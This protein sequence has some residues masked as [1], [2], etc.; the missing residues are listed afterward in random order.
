MDAEDLLWV[1]SNALTQMEGQISALR[2]TADEFR[3]YGTV[4]KLPEELERFLPAEVR[5]TSVPPSTSVP[6]RR[7]HRGKSRP[8]RKEKYSADE[9]CHSGFAKIELHCPGPRAKDVRVLIPGLE[10]AWIS[11]ECAVTLEALAEH[12]G[13][14]DGKLVAFKT[15]AELA[16]RIA[17][18]S[19]SKL[20]LHSIVSRISR[21]RKALRQSGL[22][23]T[24]RGKGVPTAYRFPLLAG[25]QIIKH[26]PDFP[27]I[28]AATDGD[29]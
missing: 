1:F 14:A 26:P 22:I 12:A 29:R 6:S 21:L 25:G 28:G 19:G 15:L 5:H 9:I 7:E 16:D 17:Q 18:F 11:P 2:D 8:Q 27:A 4:K 24:R 3:E 20:T 23:D 10:P 13:P